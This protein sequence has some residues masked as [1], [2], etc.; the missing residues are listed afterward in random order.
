MP[1]RPELD[2]RHW[3]LIC[4][5]GRNPSV[6]GG[7]TLR[8]SLVMEW[9]ISERYS[10]R[11]WVWYDAKR[12]SEKPTRDFLEKVESLVHLDSRTCFDIQ[13]HLRF[14]LVSRKF[15]LVIT[16][17]WNIS[18]KGC[19]HDRIMEWWGVWKDGTKETVG[20]AFW[21]PHGQF[22]SGPRNS[23][24]IQSTVGSPSLASE[25]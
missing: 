19:W 13:Y 25:R 20:D 16:A 4:N 1:Q 2:A 7:N 6:Q 23:Q 18:K 21:V 3:K 8:W 9:K 5:R 22:S 17:G 15:I 12:C 24:A 10:K 14:T 11:Q